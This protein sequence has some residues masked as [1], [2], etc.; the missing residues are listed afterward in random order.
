MATNTG[1]GATVA[2]S[3]A[4]GGSYLIEPGDT[5]ARIA[6]QMGVSL[7]ALLD[8]NP[9]VDPRRLRI[10]QNIVVPTAE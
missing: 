5:F 2:A 4:E 7:Q 9:G 6:Q 3:T 8:A 10:G 1:G